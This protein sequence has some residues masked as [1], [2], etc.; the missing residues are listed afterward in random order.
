MLLLSNFV[1][2]GKRIYNLGRGL[3]I[4]ASKHCRKMKFRKHTSNTSEQN[5][6]ILICLSDFYDLSGIFNI[7][8]EGS[9]SHLW[10][11]VGR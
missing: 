4:S 9:I 10:N 2:A 1:A 7:Q 8:S 3:C 11:T 6:I 5:L